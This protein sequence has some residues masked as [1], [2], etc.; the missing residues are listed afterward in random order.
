MAASEIPVDT[1]VKSVFKPLGAN[2]RK[3]SNTLKQFVGKLPSNCL[4]VFEHFVGL[5]RKELSN[6]SRLKV[7]KCTVTTTVFHKKYIFFQ[8]NYKQ[9][10]L[11]AAFQDFCTLVSV[12]PFWSN[13]TFLYSLKTSENHRFSDVFRGYRNDVT[14]K[15][16]IPV[17]TMLWVIA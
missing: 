9:V 8:S 11:T 17:N 4:S 13:V 15:C 7:R 5:A 16:D 10:L 3:W 2:P 1:S 14:S 6:V 12:N